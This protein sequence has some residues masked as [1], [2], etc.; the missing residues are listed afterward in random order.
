VNLTV[1]AN[2]PA[3]NVHP[4]IP[5][6]NARICNSDRAIDL[7]DFKEVVVV[8]LDTTWYL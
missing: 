6:S 7:K 1:Q 2:G 5:N 4:Q 8:C 3:I